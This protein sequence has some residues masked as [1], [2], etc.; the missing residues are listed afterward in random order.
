MNLPTKNYFIHRLQQGTVREAIDCLVVEEPLEIRVNG[1]ALGVVMRTPGQDFELARGF[2]LSEGIVPPHECQ[3]HLQT[4]TIA[5]A[6]DEFGLEIPNV[7]LCSLP[8][9]TPAHLRS[10]QR[11]ML[12]T[13]SCGICGRASLERVRVQAPRLADQF[14]ISANALKKMPADIRGHQM[15]YAATGGLH[16]AALFQ[17]AGEIIYACEDIGRHNAVDKVIGLAL[18][19]HSHPLSDFGLWVSGRLSFEMAQKALLAGIPFV[20]AVSAASSLAV[21]LAHETGMTLV[22]FLREDRAAVYTGKHRLR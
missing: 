11:Q 7:L 13:S 20:A 14:A 19:H 15:H 8:A 1:L 16:A 17:G 21:D 5:W 2:V 22:G 6:H 4:L 18:L 3:A 12:A 10:C 9:L